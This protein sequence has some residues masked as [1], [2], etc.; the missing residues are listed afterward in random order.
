[1]CTTRVNQHEALLV[2]KGTVTTE[3]GKS[4]L[5][6]SLGNGSP[7]D[8][9]F[10]RTG[11]ERQWLRTGGMTS[12]EGTLLV[13]TRRHGI[14][15]HCQVAPVDS[16]GQ[17]ASLVE[18]L[19]DVQRPG[20]ASFANAACAE[21]VPGSFAAAGAEFPRASNVQNHGN[22]A[23]RMLTICGDW[24]GERSAPARIATMRGPKDQRKRA[25]GDTKPGGESPI[26]G[27]CMPIVMIVPGPPAN[28][29]KAA[30]ERF[31]V[32]LT[33]CVMFG[34]TVE[35]QTATVP[36]LY[37]PT[38]SLVGVARAAEF[39][40]SHPVLEKDRRIDMQPVSNDVT[41]YTKM[42]AG[43]AGQ[44]RRAVVKV[45]CK[46]KGILQLA[47][48]R[49]HVAISRSLDGKRLTDACERNAS[50]CVAMYINAIEA[51]CSRI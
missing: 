9:S 28:K 50:S 21:S 30:L 43:V 41:G 22:M 45:L 47:K 13:I 39:A 14:V 37:K 27:R 3:P 24:R 8:R 10:G 32:P 42:S 25:T 16:R 5:R 11:R 18:H 6:R 44:Y 36:L 12:G 40:S 29:C 49:N 17:V 15:G 2:S 7:D 20:V 34:D 31:I 46:V 23:I 38:A 51:V 33:Y 26:R 19:I 48:K 35:R 1:M 4:W